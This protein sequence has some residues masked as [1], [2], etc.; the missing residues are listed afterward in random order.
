MPKEKKSSTERR[1]ILGRE[2]ESCGDIMPRK[3]NHCRLEKRVCKVHIKS[4]RCGQCNLHNHKDCDVR[5]T[6]AEWNRLKKERVRLLDE[7]E[8]AR[9][10]TSQALAKERRL[11]KQ[12]ELLD[13]R[14]GEAVAVQENQAQEAELEEFL[15]E[16]P[17]EDS[18]LALHPDTWSAMEG[19]S[20]EFWQAPV[21]SGGSAGTAVSGPSS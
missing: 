9:D 14:S 15:A 8:R 12:L 5:I 1:H 2:I 17:Q 4:G 16:L 21:T 11:M 6:E 18:S 7:I 19:L 13:T 10:A 20:D 3:C